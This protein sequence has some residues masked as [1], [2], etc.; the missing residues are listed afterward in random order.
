M[1]NEKSFRFRKAILHIGNMNMCD[2]DEHNACFLAG[3][4]GGNKQTSFV[5]I[6]TNI[7]ANT[8]THMYIIYHTY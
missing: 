1:K 5:Y 6:Y 3:L 4:F 7:Y 8:R 2:D